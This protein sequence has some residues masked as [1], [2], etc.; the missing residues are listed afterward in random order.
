RRL[1]ALPGVEAAGGIFL[2]PLSGMN[3]TTGFTLDGEPE[4][5]PTAAK[6]VASLRPVAPGYFQALGMRLLRGRRF[7]AGDD[8]R[9]RPVAVINETM[10]RSFWPGRDPIGRKV[11]FGVDFGTTGAV[12]KVSRE[13]VGIV[14]DVRQSG[15]DKDP[16]P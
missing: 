12:P 6:R 9:G 14:G 8:A 5:E 2:L 1:S 10:A 7:T 4:P 15:L 16:A 13:I 3:A 11:T